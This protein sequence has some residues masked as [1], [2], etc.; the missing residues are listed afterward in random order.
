MDDDVGTAFLEQSRHCLRIADIDGVEIVFASAA[1]FLKRRSLKFGRVEG[2]EIVHDRQLS[3]APQESLRQVRADETGSAGQQDTL[4]IH[5]ARP[6]EFGPDSA[7]PCSQ[8]LAK[9]LVQA[10][11]CDETCYRDVA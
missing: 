10:T 1:N 3:V 8:T 2:I 6:P 4:A 9:P 5:F 11:F 7:K